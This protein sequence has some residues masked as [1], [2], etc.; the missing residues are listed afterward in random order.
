MMRPKTRPRSRRANG[1]MDQNLLRGVLERGRNGTRGRGQKENSVASGS[2]ESTPDTGSPAEDDDVAGDPMEV[3]SPSDAHSDKWLG[4]SPDATVVAGSQ[5]LK[6]KDDL[7]LKADEP[8]VCESYS[9]RPSRIA[10]RRLLLRLRRSWHQSLQRILAC[11]RK[12]MIGSR[13]H[14]MTPTTTGL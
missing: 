13:S 6:P 8:F 7:E 10:K 9:S 11:L 12:E 5:P 4:R 2:K 3:D 14:Q 1:K